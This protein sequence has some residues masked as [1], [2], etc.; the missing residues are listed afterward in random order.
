MW[1]ASLVV[2]LYYCIVI[3]P[4]F[5]ICWMAM[6]K[7]SLPDCTEVPVLII[8]SVNRYL[9]AERQLAIQELFVR[10]NISHRFG[11]MAQSRFR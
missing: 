9:T 11:K 3:C 4:I 7:Y 2:F 8:S 1:V 10:C 5:F 6:L